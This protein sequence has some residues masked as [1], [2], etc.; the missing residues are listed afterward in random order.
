[1]E[2][3]GLLA[4]P[5]TEEPASAGVDTLSQGEIEPEGIDTAESE[6]SM[7]E[8]V[9]PSGAEAPENLTVG[10]Q[11]VSEERSENGVIVSAEDLIA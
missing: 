10:Q 1:M 7:S 2:R 11:D 3:V 8:D 5:N 9:K 6:I 4:K